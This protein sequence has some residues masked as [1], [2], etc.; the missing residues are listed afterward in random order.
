[1]ESADNT[2][3]SE[4]DDTVEDDTARQVV[5]F[6]LSG[7]RFSVNISDAAEIQREMELTPVPRTP[8]FVRGVVNVRGNI[9]AILDVRTFFEMDTNTEASDKVLFVKAHGLEAGLVAD[10]IEGVQA[11]DESSVHAPPPTVADVSNRWIDGMFST[12]S[13]PLIILDIP[14]IFRSDRIQNL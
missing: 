10:R 3:L 4:T 2:S 12:E 7:Q 11:L 9:K 8:D 14:E 1:M 13:T 6:E 5:V